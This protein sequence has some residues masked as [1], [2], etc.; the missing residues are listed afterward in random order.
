MSDSTGKTGLPGRRERKL[1]RTMQHLADCAW[2]LFVEYG[3]DAVT[4]DAIASTADVARGTLYKHFA[5]KEAF[6]AYR[7]RKDQLTHENMV[8]E[9]ALAA[10]SIA[11]AFHIVLQMEA[12]YAER[13]RDFIAPYV[14]YR[15]SFAKENA[16][17]FE[18]DSFAILALEL[19]QRGQS[20]GEITQQI[21]ARTLAESLIFLRLGTMLRW[22]REPEKKLGHLNAEMLQAFFQGAASRANSQGAL[23]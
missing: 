8:R 3:F 15:L 12:A 20:D 9:T 1:E 7:F 17:P 21:D 11:A 5:V 4:M 14:F 19:L 18:N 10:T 23:P 22:V 6:I 2:A 13:M 16:N